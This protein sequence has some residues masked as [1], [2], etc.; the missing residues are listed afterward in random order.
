MGS[1]L[2]RGGLAPLFDP[3]PLPTFFIHPSLILSRQSANLYSSGDKCTITFVRF[4]GC[5]P[6]T[7]RSI[8]L[9]KHS[10]TPS[11]CSGNIAFILYFT[12]NP[13]WVQT[14][15]IPARTANCRCRAPRWNIYSTNCYGRPVCPPQANLPACDGTSA[16]GPTRPYQTRL[17]E[18]G[19]SPPR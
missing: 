4:S 18:T 8:A 17:L 7:I 5:S 2:P 1:Y 14:K 19:E 13:M 11:A 12:S 9:E 15:V 3:H 10:R 16:H 6:Q